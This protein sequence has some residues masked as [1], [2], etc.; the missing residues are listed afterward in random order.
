MAKYASGS[1]PRGWA[2]A[3]KERLS[4]SYWEWGRDA[5]FEKENLSQVFPI[6]EIRIRIQVDRL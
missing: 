2:C 4:K 1:H 5:Q 3:P 6:H